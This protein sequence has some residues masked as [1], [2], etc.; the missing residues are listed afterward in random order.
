MA[1]SANSGEKFLKKNPPQKKIT[2]KGGKGKKE[3]EAP[4]EEA[5]P[6][7]APAAEPA[8]AEPTHAKS[9]SKKASTPK[10]KASSPKSSPKKSPKLARTGTMAVASEEGSDFLKHEKKRGKRAAK[11]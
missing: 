2:K 6:A 9:P 4:K 5:K 3:A 10:K 8:K 1:A 11:K 7:V